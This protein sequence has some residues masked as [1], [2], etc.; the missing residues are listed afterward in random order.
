MKNAQL[1]SYGDFRSKAHSRLPRPLFHYIDGGAGAEW[2][3]AN[4][5]AAFS[6]YQ[7]LPRA[8]VDVSAVEAGT[9]LLGRAVGMP[10]LLSPTG[11]TRLFH[12]HRELGV[13]RA[14]ALAGIPYCLSTMATTSIEAVAEVGPGVRMFQIYVL[15]DR[16]L[17]REFVQRAR[18][19]GYDAL[20]LTVDT[21]VAGVRERDRRYGMTMPPRLTAR[22]LLDFVLRPHWLANWIRD[23]DFRL[24]NITH[25]VD[26]LGAGSMGL[27]DYVN[28]QF[29]RSVTWKD[30]E[31]MA[32][33][34]GGHFVV[35]GV[36][37]LEDCRSAVDAGA[38]SLMVSN[39]GGRQ[40]DGAPAPLDVV[41]SVRSALGGAIE[42][43]VDGGVRRGG[44]IARALALGANGCSIGRPYL[45]ALAAGG[46][47]GVSRLLR[48]MREEFETTM[49]L[50]GATRPQDLGGRAIPVGHGAEP[51]ACWP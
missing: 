41:A 48:L 45:F 50:M 23:G 30:A 21:P 24:A 28:S 8:M 29:D 6:R 43:I 44:D 36:S 4:N 35:K 33:E 14:A 37:T 19:S 40:L 2:S 34:W 51:S 7:L 39:H 3:L 22:T 49:A 1:W 27:I 15:R 47:A 13:A 16:G 9:T 20:C 46:E 10:L 11:M 5:V 18:E 26:A 12:H 25:R 17:T 32:T 42:L 38:T 31:W